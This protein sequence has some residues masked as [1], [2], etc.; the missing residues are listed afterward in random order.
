MKAK[1]HVRNERDIDLFGH[2]QAGETILNSELDSR[3]PLECLKAHQSY[4][5]CRVAL[6]NPKSR[7]RGGYGG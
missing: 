2:N 3:A 5:E 6:M 7:L 4:S 1:V